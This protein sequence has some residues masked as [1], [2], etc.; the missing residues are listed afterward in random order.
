MLLRSAVFQVDGNALPELTGRPAEDHAAAGAFIRCACD[1]L[2]VVVERAAGKARRTNE[3]HVQRAATMSLAVLWQLLAAGMEHLLPAGASPLRF[4]SPMDPVWRRKPDAPAAP[5]QRS[6]IEAICAA[7]RSLL[8]MLSAAAAEQMR[9]ALYARG[10]GFVLSEAMY[11]PGGTA[12]AGLLGW[13]GGGSPN[14]QEDSLAADGAVAEL[15]L[16]GRAVLAEMRMPPMARACWLAEAFRRNQ[17][18]VADGHPALEPDEALIRRLTAVLGE[19]ASAHPLVAPLASLQFSLS[20]LSTAAE[21][22]QLGGSGGGQPGE[23]PGRLA[24]G[25]LWSA[26]EPFVSATMATVRLATPHAPAWQQL[27]LRTAKSQ[28]LCRL[29]LLLQLI[30]RMPDSLLHGRPTGAAGPGVTPRL[31]SITDLAA[32]ARLCVKALEQFVVCNV[33]GKQAMQGK[34][35]RVAAALEGLQTLVDRNAD[36]PAP[37]SALPPATFHS[38]VLAQFFAASPA[39]LGCLLSPAAAGD[40][41]VIGNGGDRAAAITVFTAGVEPLLSRSPAVVELDV[42]LR[43]LRTKLTPL[44]PK[45]TVTFDRGKL[46]PTGLSKFALPDVKHA[47]RVAFLGEAALDVR[48]VRKV[49]LHLT[50]AKFSDGATV[51]NTNTSLESRWLLEGTLYADVPRASQ[52]C[53]WA[54]PR[55]ARRA[56]PTMLPILPRQHSCVST[57]FARP[58]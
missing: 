24:A 27:G 22:K 34:D 3:E 20:E 21:T 18:R 45:V 37:E 43:L 52:P 11:T 14:D 5:G 38:H 39:H 23:R 26:L 30:R 12:V 36:A 54:V 42:K 17:N 57:S 13:L 55:G 35:P 8:P 41:V 28:Q 32:A 49:R 48:G 33:Q 50:A 46:F 1:L 44:Q 4:E 40:K 19:L 9:A 15:W 16:H 58:A 29:T 53:Q 47:W 6:I 10:Y 25:P 51:E 31:V 7:L 56:W 2:C